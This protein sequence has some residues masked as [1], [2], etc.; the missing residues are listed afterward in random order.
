MGSTPVRRCCWQIDGMLFGILGR[1]GTSEDGLHDAGVNLT[2]QWYCCS[3]AL[4]A[5]M[6]RRAEQ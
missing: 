5:R 1:V 4:T 2:A 3:V 6:A